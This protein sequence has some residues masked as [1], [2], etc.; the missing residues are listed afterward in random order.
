MAPKKLFK[1]YR[2]D[3]K[4]WDKKQSNSESES[5]DNYF[6]FEAEKHKTVES[7]KPWG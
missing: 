4:W 6:K 5:Y 3:E 2:T 1:F 7:Q